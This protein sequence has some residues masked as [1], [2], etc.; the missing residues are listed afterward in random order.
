MDLFDSQFNISAEP[1]DVTGMSSTVG[2][3]SS[4]AFDIASGPVPQESGTLG[5]YAFSEFQYRGDYGGHFL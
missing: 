2:A 5:G 3:T 1:A 4:D